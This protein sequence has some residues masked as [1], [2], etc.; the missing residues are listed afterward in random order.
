MNKYT[1]I[2]NCCGASDCYRFNS[3]QYAN[4]FMWCRIYASDFLNLVTNFDKI[5]FDNYELVHHP[6]PSVKLFGICVDNTFTA[7][8]IHYAYSKA[9]LVPRYEEP[10]VWYYR[11]Y[12]YVVEKY[13]TR[14]ARMKRN[15]YKPLFYVVGYNHRGWTAE[16]IK[17]LKEFASIKTDYQFVII[18]NYQDLVENTANLKMFYDEELTKETGDAITVVTPAYLTKKHKIQEYVKQFI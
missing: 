5:S 8:Y 12:E 4:P 16:N 1:I 3:V 15:N 18:T 11:N 14:L 13:E 7:W 9:D 6:N 17:R 2:S 10:N